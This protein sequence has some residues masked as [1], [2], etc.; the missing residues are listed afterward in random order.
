MPARETRLDALE[1]GDHLV[2]FY[3]LDKGAL[4]RNLVRFCLDG[5]R[6]GENVLVVAKPHRVEALLN[7]LSASGVD[8]QEV[9]KDERLVFFPCEETIARF[10][11]HGHPDSARFESVVASAVR[12]AR[13]RSKAGLRV[14]GEMV[15]SL[16][17]AKQ[18]RAAVRV[19]QLWRKVQAG[20]DF[21]LFCGYAI[22][23]FDAEYD[24]NVIDALLR[25]HTHQ[26]SAGR[27]GSLETA[28]NLAME[29]VLESGAQRVRDCAQSIL[30]RA[31]ASS[32]KPESAILWLRR[33]MPECAQEILS[34]ARR[35]YNTILGEAD[36]ATA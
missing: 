27:D 24:P 8:V 25:E 28:L 9:V 32:P 35:Y 3:G 22:D 18:F 12:R 10:M 19:E 29:D 26:L 1:P 11:V 20:V 21:K 14:Y 34:L 30:R 36:E 33:E 23:V 7:G 5:I 31:W 15:G 13:A 6:L 4:V 17:A 2:Q 16:W